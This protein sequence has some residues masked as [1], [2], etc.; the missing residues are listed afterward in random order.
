MSKITNTVKPYTT[1][2]LFTIF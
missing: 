2:S 1:N